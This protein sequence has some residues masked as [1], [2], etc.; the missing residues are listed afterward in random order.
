SQSISRSIKKEK[1]LYYFDWTYI[2]DPAARFENYIAVE[3]KALI[4][5]WNDLGH[6]F[7]INYLRTKEGKES[8]F[9]LIKDN[10]PWLIIE[11]KMKKQKVE[12]HH[13]HY[14][15]ILG[16]IPVLQIVMEN[17]IAEK[18]ENGYQ[19]SASRFFA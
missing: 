18:Y 12:H 7:D 17:N 8:D 14:A 10:L 9:L 16:N 1:K 19:V 11:V 4:E 13:Y 5:M 2:S 6:N 15:Q 3:L